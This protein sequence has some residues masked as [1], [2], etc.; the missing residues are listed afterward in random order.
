MTSLHQVADHPR[1]HGPH[2]SKLCSLPATVR[3]M[4][5]LPPL[6]RREQASLPLRI[7]VDGGANV[8]HGTIHNRVWVE[9]QGWLGFVCWPGWRWGQVGAA[10]ER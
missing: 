8:A 6:F 2:I 3:A 10:Q 4:G 7:V 9:G 5:S 1:A